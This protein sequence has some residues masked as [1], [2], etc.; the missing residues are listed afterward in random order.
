AAGEA[1]DGGVHLELG[2]DLPQRVHYGVVGRAACLAGPAAGQQ[3]QGGQ[4][5]RD[6][7]GELELLRAGGQVPGL[8]GRRLG[9]VQHARRRPVLLRRLLLR[10]VLAGLVL[11][12][13]CGRDGRRGGRLPVA[14]PHALGEVRDDRGGRDRNSAV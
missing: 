1:G 3:V 2:K 9:H 11:L 8:G 12:R 13:A 5:V 14:D 7:A 6:V 4:G 10:L